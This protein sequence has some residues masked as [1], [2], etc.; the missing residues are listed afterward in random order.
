[1]AFNLLKIRILPLK[2]FLLIRFNVQMSRNEKRKKPKTKCKKLSFSKPSKY[3]WFQLSLTIFMLCDDLTGRF[4][5]KFMRS[6]TLFVVERCSLRLLIL[7]ILSL[8]MCPN[9]ERGL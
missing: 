9:L 5:D 4:D 7:W 1:M 3:L 8:V 2:Y 6:L